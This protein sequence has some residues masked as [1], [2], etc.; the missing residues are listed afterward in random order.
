MLNTFGELLA[1]QYN[2]VDMQINSKALFVSLCYFIDLTNSSKLISK[3][4]FN[5]LK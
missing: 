4:K 2:E 1:G 5:V 3:S